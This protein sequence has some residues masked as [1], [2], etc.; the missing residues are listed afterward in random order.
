MLIANNRIITVLVEK[1]NLAQLSTFPV[2]WSLAVYYRGP[3]S[4]PLY[5]PFV[6]KCNFNQLIINNKDGTWKPK[7]VVELISTIKT[8][9]EHLLDISHLI[10]QCSVQ[11][12][13]YK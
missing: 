10:K 11:R 1:L 7:H 3:T 6:D 13:R 4:S 12:S 2:V 5:P 8:A 9:Y